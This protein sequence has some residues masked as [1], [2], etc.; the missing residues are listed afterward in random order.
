[1][2]SRSTIWSW[3]VAAWS[4]I[5]A[6]AGCEGIIDGHF[7]DVIGEPA[8]AASG[9]GSGGA[10]N[11]TGSSGSTT[12]GSA[13]QGGACQGCDGVC[14][15]QQ[16]VVPHSSGL[17]LW[18]RSDK[19]LT[20]DTG[21]L[22][23]RDQISGNDAIGSDA[24]DAQSSTV[25]EIR[26]STTTFNGHPFVRFDGKD[27]RLR[28]P[29]VDATFEQGITAAFAVRALGAGPSNA[30]D[31]FLF[32]GHESA[33]DVYSNAIA[34]G[35][36]LAWDRL[37]FTV[38]STYIPWEYWNGIVQSAGGIESLAPSAE[39]VV[40]VQRAD[41]A[42]AW[43]YSNGRTVTKDWGDAPLPADSLRDASW[44]GW[45]PGGP[46]QGDIAE[47]LLYNRAVGD[48]E[49]SELETYLATKYGTTLIPPCTMGCPEVLARGQGLATHLAYYGNRIVWTNEEGGEVMTIA[50]VTAAAPMP[51]VLFGGGVSSVNPRAPAVDD[52]YV[53]WGEEE[54]LLHRTAISG[55]D[56][57]VNA[58]GE[59]RNVALSAGTA[60]AA[61]MG[62]GIGTISQADWSQTTATPVGESVHHVAVDASHV[63]WSSDLEG[64]LDAVYRVPKTQ[65][66]VA[67]RETVSSTV[68]PRQVVLDA[69]HVYFASTHDNVYGIH[70]VSKS[71]PPQPTTLVTEVDAGG[72]VVALAVSGGH[73]YY[74]DKNHGTVHRAPVTGGSST[75][76]AS[77]QQGPVGIA[78]VGNYV[79]WANRDGT[80]VRLPKPM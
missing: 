30:Y 47:V 6:T 80:I 67:S 74:T 51:E 46:F 10:G 68:Y 31:G 33:A 4:L 29:D 8:S 25:P 21:E 1:M 24:P 71:A 41:N 42:T 56:E 38:Q 39:I 13:G 17:M 37:R 3:R 27:D 34:I 23:W 53:Y 45:V 14:I 28:L 16:C 50:D 62:S 61:L 19:E 36:E 20:A 65:I 18:L 59:A 26:T 63:Y 11:A 73:V 70:R 69:T 49:R 40:L 9:A 5:A 48:A 22:R 77:E 52:A 15:E 54:W 64:G 12:G 57:A 79:V 55:G 72:D 35:R 78:V 32:L 60:Y 44:L 75:T 43:F 7:D 58:N 76:L 66:G 2:A